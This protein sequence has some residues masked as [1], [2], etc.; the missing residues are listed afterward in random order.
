MPST[1]D[2]AMPAS[3]RAAVMAWHASDSS[4]PSSD[5]PYAV[6]PIPAIAVRS[7]IGSIIVF[8]GLCRHSRRKPAK[9]EGSPA[10]ELGGAA[11]DEGQHPLL[12]VLGATHQLLC[13][14]L[15]PEGGGA[16]GVER[17]IGEPLGEGDGL[18]GAGGEAPGQLGEGLLEL[19]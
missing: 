14:A 4:V 12:G 19:G 17:T 18:G 11:L 3:S 16:I 7:L 15:V 6:C 2:G 10:L 1:S 8:A 5:L 9:S 13:V